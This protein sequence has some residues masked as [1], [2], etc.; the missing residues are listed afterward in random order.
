MQLAL[1]RGKVGRF[2]IKGREQARPADSLITDTMFQSAKNAITSKAAKVYVNGLLARYG[3]VQELKIDSA[4]H[5]ITVTIQLLGEPAPIEA[6][7]GRYVIHEQ[8]GKKFI[9]FSQCRCSRPWMQALLEDVTAQ[10]RVELPAW[11][12]AAL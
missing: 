12:A 3:E 7:V 2:T 9:E 5:T 1:T 10:R 8:G 4:A 6:K 11:A